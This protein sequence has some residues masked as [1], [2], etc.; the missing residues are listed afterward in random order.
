ME[1]SITLGDII[2]QVE[3]SGR[4]GRL[5][6]RSP[7][8]EGDSRE[9]APCGAANSTAAVNLCSGVASEAREGED[10][11]PNRWPVDLGEEKGQERNGL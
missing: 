3:T 11:G 8:S 9:S 2:D 4:L 10:F 6:S 7:A 1:P 5:S